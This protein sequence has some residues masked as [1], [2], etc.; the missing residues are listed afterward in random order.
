MKEKDM[1]PPLTTPIKGEGVIVTKG[2]IY[3]ETMKTH[4]FVLI[5]FIIF[6]LSLTSSTSVYAQDDISVLAKQ[7]QQS[8]VD[9]LAYDKNGA[10]INQGNG[11]FVNGDGDVIT[12]IHVLQGAATARVKTAYGKM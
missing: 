3:Y 11:V 2:L 5:S 10:L 1:H 4:R 12:N 7:I 6:I 8:M 9:V